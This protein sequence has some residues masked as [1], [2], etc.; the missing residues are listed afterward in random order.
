MV[1]RKPVFIKK[2]TR[3]GKALII[4]VPKILADLFEGRRVQCEVYDKENN[5]EPERTG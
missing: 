4:I 5:Y 3:M 2:P 1:K